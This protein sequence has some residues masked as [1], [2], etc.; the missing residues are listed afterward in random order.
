[1]PLDGLLPFLSHLFSLFLTNN[2]SI[3]SLQRIF[4]ST[5]S[6]VPMERRGSSRGG[7]SDLRRIAHDG[8]AAN[9]MAYDQLRF[10]PRDPVASQRRAPA[11]VATAAE[12]RPGADKGEVRWRYDPMLQSWFEV[13]RPKTSE[14]RHEGSSPQQARSVAAFLATTPRAKTSSSSSPGRKAVRF[15]AS[16]DVS[17][18]AEVEE[19]AWPSQRQWTAPTPNGSADPPKEGLVFTDQMST[20]CEWQ[21]FRSPKPPAFPIPVQRIV[22][23]DAIGRDVTFVMSET[24]TNSMIR[25]NA[26]YNTLAPYIEAERPLSKY[27][28]RARKKTEP[29]APPL[30]GRRNCSSEEFLG[31]MSHDFVPV[32]VKP[33]AQQPSLD[34]M[35]YAI[36]APAG[37][38]PGGNG[39]SN[40]IMPT[41]VQMLPTK[42]YGGVM[43][44]GLYEEEIK[45]FQRPEDRG[46]LLK[47]NSDVLGM[48]AN[49]QPRF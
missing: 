18:G 49:Y 47:A 26:L 33:G 4:A 28:P 7:Y 15:D 1:M 39:F 17:K 30:K 19:Q 35:T 16:I 44:P 2:S 48:V 40:H 10:G 8:D 22:V 6:I 32:N 13:L 5:A 41:G 45:T 27:S 21:S 11:A 24:P 42:K 20:Q 29:K 38:L 25:V 34:G 23:K 37:T 43:H 9:R 46:R 12:E 31:S 36:W 3:S 14:E